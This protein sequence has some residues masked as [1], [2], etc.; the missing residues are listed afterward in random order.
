VTPVYS[1]TDLQLLQDFRIA[2]DRRFE[3]SFYVLNLF[4]HG[5]AIGRHLTYQ[6]TNG[7][8]PNEV[9]FY[10]GQQTSHN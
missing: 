7:V 9:L 10:T 1:Q 5:A 2:G 3:I 4:D 6:K 8:V